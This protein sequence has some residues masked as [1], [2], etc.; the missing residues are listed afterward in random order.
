METGEEKTPALMGEG[1]TAFSE[2]KNPQEYSRKYINDKTQRSDVTGYAPQYDYTL[3]CIDGDPVVAEIVKVHDNELTGNEAKRYI[4]TVNLWSDSTG[5]ACAAKRRLYTIVPDKKADGTDALVYSGSMKA[6]G[7]I[8]A[9]TF[10]LE[11]LKFTP[12]ADETAAVV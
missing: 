1:F 7:D 11:N 5:K 2:S 6:A 4:I 9:G 3:D 10:D 8:E 12:T